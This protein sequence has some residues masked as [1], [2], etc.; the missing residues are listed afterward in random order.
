VYHSTTAVVFYPAVVLFPEA[1]HVLNTAKL[2]L[3][4]LL[5]TAIGCGGGQTPTTS[6][7]YDFT[8]TVTVQGKPADRVALYLS[9]IEPG[10]GREDEQCLVTQGKYTFTKVMA[11]KYKVY[12]QSVGGTAI[13]KKYQSAATSGFELDASSKGGEQ[14]FDMK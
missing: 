10:K 13:P 2:A 11:G 12:F 9:P 3:P 8:G 4:L 7:F 14:N 6:E 1:S 5:T